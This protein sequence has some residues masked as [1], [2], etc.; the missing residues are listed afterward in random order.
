MY[1]EQQHIF[2]LL[3]DKAITADRKIME[4]ESG[5]MLPERTEI[6]T[7]ADNIH[8][9]TLASAPH[10]RE[11][12]DTSIDSVAPQVIV[13]EFMWKYMKE[14]VSTKKGVRFRYIADIT[15]ENLP[16]CKEMAKIFELRH[17]DGIKGNLSVIDRREYRVSPKVRPGSPPGCAY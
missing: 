2:D 4:I 17:L 12:L 5:M 14:L 6:I 1:R 11:S 16:Y 3:W 7:G 9:L 13:S 8:R 15:K 10:I